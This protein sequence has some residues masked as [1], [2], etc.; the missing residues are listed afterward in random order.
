MRAWLVLV[1]IAGCGRS[2]E[3]SPAPP[4]APKP[5]PHVVSA[6]VDAAT[7]ASPKP[8]DTAQG[9]KVV[10]ASTVDGTALR[11]KH[12]ERLRADKTPVTVLTGGTAG[13]LGQRLC[14]AVVPTRPPETP[15]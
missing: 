10:V 1:A 6:P 12:R 2:E 11:A 8:D 13:E 9:P 15:V 14:E 5:P 4:A 7:A 3:P